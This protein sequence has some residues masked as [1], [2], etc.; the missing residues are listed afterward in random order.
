M[1]PPVN[2][3]PISL[4]LEL[5]PELGDHYEDLYDIYGEDLTPETVFMELADVVTNLVV[6]SRDVDTLWR[7]IEAVEEVAICFPEDADLVGL[8][9]LNQLPPCALSGIEE[10]LGDRTL[11]IRE[12]LAA[13][14][15][16]E[17]NDNEFSASDISGRS[18]RGH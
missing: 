12:R 11:A 4:L 10:W 3:A 18:N 5:V 16:E 7:C 6:T 13:G 2:Q 17:G 9:F 15:P 8:C 14:W 1:R